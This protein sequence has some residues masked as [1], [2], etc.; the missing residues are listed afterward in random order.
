MATSSL[1]WGR[2]LL[3]GV[4]A[5]LLLIAAVIPMRM[6][7]SS[8]DAITILAVAGSFLV[9]VPVAWWLARSVGRPVTHGVLMGA[10]AAAI[11]VLL[12]VMQQL[13]DPN[14]PTVPSIYY[15]AHVLKLAGGAVGGWLA[16]RSRGAVPTAAR[17]N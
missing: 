7:G 9:F 15:V 12:S 13:F 6:T 2:I 3:G 4:L 5:E 8:D 17:V 1:R 11:Y 10:A 16:G 14:A